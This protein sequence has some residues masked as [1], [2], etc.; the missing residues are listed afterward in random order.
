MVLYWMRRVWKWASLWVMWLTH[1]WSL[2]EGRIQRFASWINN[3]DHCVKTSLLPI[4]SISWQGLVFLCQDAPAY[5]A[6]VM[7]LWVSSVD[8]TG[9]VLI[10]PQILRQMSDI[11]RKLRGTLRYLLG[12]LHDWRVCLWPETLCRIALFFLL[13]HFSRFIASILCFA[14]ATVF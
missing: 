1:L 2:K 12:N 6:D 5:G 3:R 4:E 7:R 14:S 13:P 10:G 9:D 11:Y 8:Y